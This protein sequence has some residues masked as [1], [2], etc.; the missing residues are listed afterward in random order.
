MK[1]WIIIIFVSG[2]F[3]GCHYNN[4]GLKIYNN[5]NEYL[6][7]EVY[8]HKDLEKNDVYNKY[9]KVYYLDDD[10]V[11]KPQDSVR[12]VHRGSWKYNI[13]TTSK[14]ST[15]TVVFFNRDSIKKYGWDKIIESKNYKI[16]TYKVNDLE[17]IRWNVEY[18]GL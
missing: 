12:P 4:G 11:L 13:E 16:Q 2:L 3:L 10:V 5:S 8:F 9:E 1:K 6:Y 15:L 18:N 17:R 7:F 14:D